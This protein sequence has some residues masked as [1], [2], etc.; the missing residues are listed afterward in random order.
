MSGT[1]AKTLRWVA[2]LAAAAC[3]VPAGAVAASRGA[4]TAAELERAGVAHGTRYRL[5]MMVEV[6][7]AALMADAFAREVDFFAIGTNDLIQYSLA[8]D[9]NN[10]QVA[11]LFQPLHPA[12]LR[13]L[14]SVIESGRGAGIPVSLCGEMGGDERYLPLLVGLGLRDGL[15]LGHQ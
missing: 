12:I 7:A 5:G 14:R 6:P 13:M 2:A 3:L 4:P 8:V 11:D 10:R 9:R 15:L 1:D